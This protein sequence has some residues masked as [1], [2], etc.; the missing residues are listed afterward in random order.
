MKEIGVELTMR[1]SQL[2]DEQTV[3]ESASKTIPIIKNNEEVVQPTAAWSN[4]SPSAPTLPNTVINNKTQQMVDMVN[5]VENLRQNHFASMPLDKKLDLVLQKTIESEKVAYQALRG[6]NEFSRRLDAVF[7][8]LSSMI[9]R[10]ASGQP[11]R[12]PDPPG[13]SIWDED[14]PESIF[15]R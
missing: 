12:E 3:I 5:T 7:K 2:G 6:V 13:S 1:L 14:D 8:D 15:G 9:E 10:V 11:A 4:V